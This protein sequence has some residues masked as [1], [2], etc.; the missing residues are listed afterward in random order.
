MFIET[1]PNRA[2]PPAV[3]L[4]E[5]YRD[6]NGRTQKRTLANLSKLP[7]DV[8]AALKAIL[9]GGTLIGAGREELQIERSLPHGHVAAALGMIRKIGLDRLILSTA[10]DAEARRYC[11][12]VVAMMVDRLIAPRS[13]LGFVRAVDEET[14]TTSLGEVLGLGKVKDREA[15]QA[16]DW[17]LE[18]QVRIEN[19]LARRHLEDGV[20][21]LYDV[22]SSYFEG[23]HC[24]LAQY[25]HSRDHR[26]DRLQIVYGL[27]CT[28]EGLPIAV[29]V[30]EGNTA[31]PTTL[32]S[33]ID[34]LRSRFGIKRMVLVGDRGMITA[35]RIRD[36][37]KSS[38]LD[39]I[40]CLRAPQIQAL[41]QDH[42]PL[43]FS[44]FDERDLAEI[45]SP[46]FPGERLIVCRNR[47]LAAERAR[48]REALLVVTERELARIQAQVRRKGSHLHAAV[49]IGLAVGEV[50]NAKKMAKHFA[51]DIRDGHF[52]WARKVDQIA[53][54]AKL[55]GIYVIR[56]SVPAED[57]GP[58]HAVQAYK[59]LSR[60]ER[61]F[62]S[63]KTVDLEI[64]PIRHWSADR[65]RAHVFLCMLAYHVEWHLRQVLAPLLFHDTDLDAA[66]AE[67]FSPVAATEPSATARAKKAT[68]R[69]ANG[70]RINSFAGL[71]DHLGTLTRNTMRMPLAA[72]HPFTLLSKSTPLQEAT[73]KLLGFHPKRVQ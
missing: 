57:L 46:D 21:V 30:F 73:F 65:V 23:R 2:S 61:A 22:S 71:I 43:Q 18:R 26:S 7:G 35:A 56:T 29:E 47:D 50:V 4:R 9:K 39:W 55:D 32:K 20:L 11:D 38:G 3:L 25:G 16:L 66:R 45:S 17:L 54:E 68:K 53:A 24:P 12:L 34:K 51:L 67:R 13:K 31:D 42:G 44:L 37:L 10:R 8:V 1:V 5:S 33:Q 69:N 64:R 60:V 14:A 59:D 72:K 15:Y 63:M 49:E 48:K 52:T 58:A 28:R 62:R 70:D 40:T 36:D 6:E 27:L 19:G 41:A